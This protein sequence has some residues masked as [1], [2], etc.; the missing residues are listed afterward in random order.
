[1]RLHCRQSR[2]LIVVALEVLRCQR[3]VRLVSVHMDSVALE[4]FAAASG[5]TWKVHVCVHWNV[6]VV[7]T[8]TSGIGDLRSD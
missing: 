8:P 6:S 4:A 2:Y 3:N 5:C 1:M 7:C